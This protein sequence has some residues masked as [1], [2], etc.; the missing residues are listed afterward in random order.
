MD[1]MKE[2]QFLNQWVE[3]FNRKSGENDTHTCRHG[4]VNCSTY[5]GGRCFDETLIQI[6]EAMNKL[7]G[8]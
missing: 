8:V 6:D 4:H 7:E 3:L 2:V 5:D 1:A